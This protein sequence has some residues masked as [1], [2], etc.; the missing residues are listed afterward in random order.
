MFVN[1][2]YENCSI[3]P[4][5]SVCLS[6]SLENMDFSNINTYLGVK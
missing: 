1:L 6:H 5:F 2:T 4:I 3:S